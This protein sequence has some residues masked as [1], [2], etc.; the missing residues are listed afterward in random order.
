MAQRAVNL[1][2]LPLQ[3]QDPA[4]ERTLARIKFWDEWERMKWF[5]ELA[6]KPLKEMT[7]GEITTIQEEIRAMVRTLFHETTPPLFDKRKIIRLQGT[8]LKHLQ[9]LIMT[10]QTMF[11]NISMRLWIVHLPQAINHSK[12]VREQHNRSGPDFSPPPRDLASWLTPSS[13]EKGLISEMG[14]LLRK[15]GASIRRCPRC[16]KIYLQLRT[17]AGYCSRECQSRA[18]TK[19]KRDEKKERGKSRAIRNSR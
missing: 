12:R 17:T 1:D 13:G 4:D 16:T 5:V 14:Q 6:Q 3:I 2:S 9:E 15:Y 7:Q 19:K 10:G 11:H 18:I 8:L